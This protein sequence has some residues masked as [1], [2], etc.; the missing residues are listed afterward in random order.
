[1]TFRLVTLSV[2]WVS[3]V[4]Q[5]GAPSPEKFTMRVVATA[6]EGPWDMVNG[7][8]GRIW[9]T[10]RVGKRI[11]RVNPADGTKATAVTIPDIVQ[12]HSQDGLLG[13]AFS[14]G[15]DALFAALT[16]DADPGPQETRRLMIRRYSWNPGSETLGNPI[17][18]LKG[19]P[20]GS[21]H[22]SGRLVLGRDDKLYLTIGDQGYNQLSL[23][24]QPIHSQDLPSAADVTS[25]NWYWYEGKVLRINLDGSIPADNPML[26][27]VRSHIYSYGH[28]NAQ[29]LI[30]SPDGQIYASEHGPSMDDELN[31][32]VAGRNY[33]W[34]FVAGYKDD[35]VYTY[36]KWAESTTPCATMKHDPIVAPQ[37]V[38]QQKESAWNGPGFMPP[39]QTFFTVD[40]SYR[41]D[42]GNATI[43]PSGIDIYTQ[44]GIP[45]WANSVLITSL[46]R[47]SVYRVKLSADGT[48]A[49]G[50]PLEY[51]KMKTRYRDVLVAP[52]G[53]TIYAA[54][55]TNS[56]E[57]PGAILAFT[58]Q[59]N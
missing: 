6:L 27:G 24:C 49:S 43:A 51:F 50:E 8:D 52:D 40:S 57:N 16:Y 11:T 13:I 37:P 5:G 23:L 9:V 54:T 22:I 18:V 55:D 44:G 14:R 47:G 28:R 39:I 58:Y 46:L 35:K 48:A 7:P 36:A 45:G 33:G 38:P 34:P 31:L 32:I 2:L 17:D 1:M 42:T 56:A 19:L 53:R 21:D 3:L 59:G 10:E 29:G 15:G 25:A 30:V 41:F 12:R 26:A 4:P 20:A